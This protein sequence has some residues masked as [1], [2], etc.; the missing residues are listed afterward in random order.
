MSIRP[1]SRVE[2][3]SGISPSSF[4]G[5]IYG[6]SPRRTQRLAK[7]ERVSASRESKSKSE[8]AESV[9]DTVD[10][11]RS[12]LVDI[13]STMQNLQ[14]ST[15]PDPK[16]LGFVD[17]DPEADMAEERA[18]Q[19][20]AHYDKPSY[21]PVSHPIKVAA[22]S[23]IDPIRKRQGW[24][25]IGDT[26]RRDQF[27]TLSALEILIITHL[28]HRDWPKG[29][30]R[31]HYRTEKVDSTKRCIHS[32]FQVYNPNRTLLDLTLVYNAVSQKM[33]IHQANTLVGEL[34]YESVTNQT[35]VE[36]ITG[37]Y[38]KHKILIDPVWDPG[39]QDETHLQ[40]LAAGLFTCRFEKD[41]SNI[42]RGDWTQKAE[43]YAFTTRVQSRQMSHTRYQSKK[44]IELGRHRF[45]MTHNYFDDCISE[46]YH[47]YGGLQIR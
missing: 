23:Q 45:S 33:Q 8:S 42:W 38:N 6:A 24:A 34:A 46:P 16:P 41:D 12:P 4:L 21:S 7:K 13:D 14:K 35:A 25:P 32:R 36:E 40:H 22:T 27:R 11:D 15:T 1:I 30:Y 2:R 5:A 28:L 43:R 44:R 3:H 31:L 47:A 17:Y 18:A 20:E 39:E 26:H 10:I 9:L 19:A 29:K 37:H